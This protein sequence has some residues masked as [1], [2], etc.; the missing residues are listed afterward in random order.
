MAC[1]FPSASS[2]CRR[3]LA[4]DHCLR[5]LPADS[6]S[7]DEAPLALHDNLDE[8]DCKGDDANIAQDVQSAEPDERKVIEATPCS[9]ILVTRVCRIL[10]ISV[11]IYF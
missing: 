1:A 10:L 9:L 2:R 3:K 5:V 4:C 8:H 11:P 7:P 6:S